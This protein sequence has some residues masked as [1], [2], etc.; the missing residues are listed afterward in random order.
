MLVFFDSREA[1]VV[2]NQLLKRFEPL[3][4]SIELPITVSDHVVE[5]PLLFVKER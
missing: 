1:G 2:G 4:R 5:S 3:S